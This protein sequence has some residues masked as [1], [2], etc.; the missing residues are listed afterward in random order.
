MII[1]D[2]KYSIEKLKMFHDNPDYVILHCG[3]N[4]IG[5]QPGNELRRHIKELLYDGPDC[6]QALL[7]NTIFIWSQI[8]PR[9]TWR[10]IPLNLLANIIRKRINSCVGAF[11]IKK[12][13]E[14]TSSILI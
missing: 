10:Y 6:L 8:I 13:A 7:P 14:H 11:I 4:N 12:K 5:R 1:Q 3:G 9:R 2:V